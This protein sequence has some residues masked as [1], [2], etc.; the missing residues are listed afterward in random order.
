LIFRIGLVVAQPLQVDFES[1]IENPDFGKVRVTGFEETT[2]SLLEQID[3]QD[4]KAIFLIY[5]GEYDIENI[6]SVLGNYKVNKTAIVFTPRFPPTPGLSYTILFDN[7]LLGKI[8]GLR[9]T[10][11][12]VV[13]KVV[14]V[15]S[16][17][18]KRT[19]LDFITPKSDSVPANIL[20][21]YLHFSS[22]MSFENPYIH[23]KIL[24]HM[25]EIVNQPF[26]EVKKGL[27]DPERK[28]L[29]LFFHP[30]R[31]KRG[32]GPNMTMG[33]IFEPDHHYTMVVSEN[34][35]DA[36]GNSLGIAYEKS[37]YILPADRNRVD[38]FQWN[39][40]QVTAGTL[41]KL[42]ISF[43]EVLDPGLVSRMITLVLENGTPVPGNSSSTVS[44]D[45]WQ[46]IPETHWKRGDY[47]IMV[48]A[49]LEDL[50]G[51]SVGQIFEKKIEKNTLPESTNY[52]IYLS[53]TV[54]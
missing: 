39:L 38:P 31:I 29:T 41:D 32:V 34:W 53:L 22:P 45:A 9:N 52:F 51:N 30:G 4:W 21:M 16:I 44:Q 36:H 35:K 17:D 24:N 20:R 48:D 1:R 28:R 5:T 10:D 46:F 11:S 3:Q 19:L 7:Q 26:V 43:G 49:K 40:T 8:V 27:W 18:H 25:G 33:P 23:V 50:A 14:K 6:P 12:T 54:Q 47:L 13:R 42:T 15:P 37:L 2:I